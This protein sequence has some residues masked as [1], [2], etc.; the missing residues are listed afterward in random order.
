MEERDAV[1]AELKPLLNQMIEVVVTRHF[2][3][4]QALSTLSA[5][6]LAAS[7]SASRMCMY[8]ALTLHSMYA[9]NDV[10]MTM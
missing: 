2:V 8:P 4:E 6:S 7:L 9:S 10:M 5:T 1:T 3:E